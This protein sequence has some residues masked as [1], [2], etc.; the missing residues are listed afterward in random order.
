MLPSSTPT[1][2]FGLFAGSG[3]HFL[4]PPAVGP[5][6]E[7]LWQ[8][9]P[10]SACAAVRP[11]V[12][13]M[14]AEKSP[15]RPCRCA[16]QRAS[17]STRPEAQSERVNSRRA[18]AVPRGDRP[19]CKRRRSA[20][21]R[22]L[23][24]PYFPLR[25]LANRRDAADAVAARKLGGEFSRKRTR[26]R[27]IPPRGRASSPLL[28]MVRR[29]RGTASIPSALGERGSRRVVIVV[30]QCFCSYVLPACCFVRAGAPSQFMRNR[31]GRRSDAATIQS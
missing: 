2:W 19:S 24:H 10:R 30:L 16:D 28:L 8:A 27:L 15:S 9:R 25:V 4:E 17:P 5:H 6:A 11:Q 14:S 31:S 18:T 1:C 20:G 22:P 3:S 12:P 13:A 29:T 23:L 21:L 7:F 26:G